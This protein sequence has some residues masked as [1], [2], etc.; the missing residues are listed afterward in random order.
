MLFKRLCE[1][2]SVNLLIYYN[3]IW[4]T[5]FVASMVAMPS[6][7]VRLGAA[8]CHQAAFPWRVWW[9]WVHCIP[10]NQGIF[11]YR[12]EMS[13]WC[14]CSAEVILLLRVSS[15]DFVCV[16]KGMLWHAR[17]I[18]AWGSHRRGDFWLCIFCEFIFGEL[19][20]VG[21][22]APC[23]RHCWYQGPSWEAFGRVP[24]CG[25]SVGHSWPAGLRKAFVGEFW[26]W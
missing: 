9:Q 2:T 17:G 21:E 3:F 1:I 24:G 13:S 16:P 5:H 8:A 26:W 20:G 25:W 11:H 15:W 22:T 18:S 10:T 19:A 7:R 14:L 23:G 12:F 4:L 6:R